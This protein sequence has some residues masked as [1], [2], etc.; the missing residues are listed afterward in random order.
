MWNNYPNNPTGSGWSNQYEEVT[1]ICDA[2]LIDVKCY[3]NLDQSSWSD[4]KFQLHNAG[5][6]DKEQIYTGEGNQYGEFTDPYLISEGITNPHALYFTKE[7][8]PDKLPYQKI[9][10]RFES[11]GKTNQ[12][13]GAK[14]GNKQPKPGLT[15]KEKK[16]RERWNNLAD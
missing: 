2:V 9:S 7:N 13:I 14:C 15:K 11:V 4:N 12:Y 10:V 8:N 3:A 16:R 1:P 5:T 6:R